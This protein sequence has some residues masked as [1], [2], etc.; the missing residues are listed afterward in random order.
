M[1]PAVRKTACWHLILQQI[2]HLQIPKF[3]MVKA[4]KP[5]LP[6]PK[7]GHLEM[8]EGDPEILEVTSHVK[9]AR[10]S[11]APKEVLK[12]SRSAS[13]LWEEVLFL[14]CIL[15]L[16][17]GGLARSTAALFTTPFD[18]VKTRLQTEVIWNAS[19]WGLH[20][21]SRGDLGC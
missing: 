21:Y 5:S 3:E 13:K 12:P 6:A 20:L 9:K 14:L 19:Y 2:V 16:L 1:L 8:N 15:P 10:V 4:L 11:R 7:K 17:C 18:V